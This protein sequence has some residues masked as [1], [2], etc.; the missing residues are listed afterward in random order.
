MLVGICLEFVVAD[1]LSFLTFIG[2]LLLFL[3]L[4]LIMMGLVVPLLILWFGLLVQCLRGEGLFMLSVILPCFLG[5]P[6]IWLG[7]W[8]AGPS[9][10]IGA[11]D[12]A[13]WPYTPGLLVKWFSFL[14]SL[15][16]P[17]SGFGLGVGG[18][19][20]VE[21]LILYELW[22]G[23]RL[24]LEKA[25]PRYL[26][27]GRPI[28]VSAVPLGPGIDIW[29]SCRCI[30]ALMRTF[31]L[32]FGGAAEVCPL[33]ALFVRTPTWRLPASGHVDRLVAAHSD[34]AGD[35]GGEVLGLGVHRVS[36]SGP[37]RKRFRLNRKTPAHLAGLLIHS[38]PRVWKRLRHVGFFRDFHA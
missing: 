14:S 4:L 28:S 18:V 10:S 22:A 5:P 26:L 36:G 37:V 23:E 17:A 30:G 35:H 11:D 33:L 31:C 6:A 9:V 21:L 7:E 8:V 25:N 38:R 29:R 34:T 3:G 19:S 2:S 24:V 15:H 27:P 16:W 20:Y 13:Q 1:T 32:L 12:V